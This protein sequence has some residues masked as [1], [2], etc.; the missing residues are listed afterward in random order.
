QP[1]GHHPAQRILAVVLPLLP[2][3]EGADVVGVQADECVD[4]LR[5]HGCDISLE[6]LFHGHC[7]FG[8]G[9]LHDSA[10][11]RNSSESASRSSCV[12]GFARASSAGCSCSA[13]RGPM[14]TEMRS[15]A[16]SQANASVAGSPRRSSAS[17]ASKTASVRRCSYGADRKVIRE[18][19]GAAASRRYLPVSQP[20]MSGDG[21]WNQRPGSAQSGSTSSSTS[22]SRSEYES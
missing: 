12:R 14:T 19:S 20:P 10:A 5:A 17:S 13:R 9:R 6:H 7:S 22:R 4:V 8:G 18:P 2:E 16:N 21:T 1:P 15:S 11:R 3:V